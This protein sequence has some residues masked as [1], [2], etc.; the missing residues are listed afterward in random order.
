M[1]GFE[2]SSEIINSEQI[3]GAE[4]LLGVKFPVEYRQVVQNFGGSSG[5]VEFLV[6]RP[7]DGFDRCGIG[8][9]LSLLPHSR[10]SV[11]RVMAAW[12]E[13]ELPAQLIPVAEDGGGNYLCL[14]YRNGEEPEVV[15]YFHEL[16]GDDGIIFVCPTFAG[17]IARL[18]QPDDDED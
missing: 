6:D 17:F 8:L 3:D 5:D 16:T 1:L 14:D 11:Y 10:N 15:F 13:H 7:S 12:E 4:R 2:P 18:V 9:V